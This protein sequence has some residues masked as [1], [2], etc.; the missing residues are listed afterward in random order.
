MGTLP[1]F[2]MAFSIFNYLASLP[3]VGGGGAC[4][5]PAEL[6]WK[7]MSTKWYQK[8]IWGRFEVILVNL[9]CR[10]TVS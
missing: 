2:F 1:E 4:Q 7:K 8:V 3:I 6:N 5:E 10:I 9:E